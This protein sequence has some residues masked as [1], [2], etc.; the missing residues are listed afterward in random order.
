MPFACCKCGYLL[1]RGAIGSD[2][3]RTDD[4]STI[5]SF[6]SGLCGLIGQAITYIRN[7]WTRLTRFLE[8]GRI[9][10]DNGGVERTIRPVAIGRKNDLFAG[11]CRGARNAASIYSL[12]ATCALN[13]V[14]PDQYLADVL[15]KLIHDWP[16]K[17]IDDLLP[18]RWKILFGQDTLSHTDIHA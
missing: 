4:G 18:D 12:M 2:G 11:S 9:P 3:F 14:Q 1:P 13:D 6:P 7:Q 8:D 16:A 10:L 15:D 17:A 5:P